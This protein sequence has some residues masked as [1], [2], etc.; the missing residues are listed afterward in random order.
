VKVSD[1]NRRANRTCGQKY[2]AV[3]PDTLTLVGDTLCYSSELHQ[4]A[5]RLSLTLF[6]AEFTVLQ[7]AKGTAVSGIT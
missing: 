2:V 6:T 3:G 4:M 7:A 5:S 1:A